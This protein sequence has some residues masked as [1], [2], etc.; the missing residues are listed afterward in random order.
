[1][2]SHPAISSCTLSYWLETKSI[3]S[4]G[5]T[6]TQRSTCLSL[7]LKACPTTPRQLML[8]WRLSGD[9]CSQYTLPFPQHE[10]TAVD[11][12]HSQQRLQSETA[13]STPRFWSSPSSCSLHPGVHVCNCHVFVGRWTLSFPKWF[14][15]FFSTNFHA[16]YKH[17]CSLTLLCHTL[18]PLYCLGR[19]GAAYLDTSSIQ[20]KIRCTDIRNN[21]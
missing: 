12:L 18:A 16:I 6:R 3:D 9:W 17:V 10:Y 20:C 21:G 5:W 7:E 15:D 1:M 2:P 13:F 4:T 8:F 14:Y 19:L 11:T